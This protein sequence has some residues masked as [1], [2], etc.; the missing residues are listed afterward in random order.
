MKVPVRQFRCTRFTRCQKPCSEL[1]PV[2][3]TKYYW[4]KQSRRK[5][6]MQAHKIMHQTGIKN[7]PVRM[8]RRATITAMNWKLVQRNQSELK[9]KKLVTEYEQF[10][11][12]FER[13]QIDIAPCCA[14][15]YPRMEADLHLGVI[16]TRYVKCFKLRK[17]LLGMVSRAT[18]KQ[19]LFDF[20]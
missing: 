19:C 13:K 5:N 20:S 10:M 17:A 11:R 16:Q 8:Q 7:P 14:T 3:W 1:S 12:K 6:E 9:T 2:Y 4:D 18:I 15:E